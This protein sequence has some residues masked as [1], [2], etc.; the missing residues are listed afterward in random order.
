M[1]RPILIKAQMKPLLSISPENI[2]KLE[3]FWRFK[4]G[5]FIWGLFSMDR[6]IDYPLQGIITQS[7]PES[8]TFVRNKYNM[9]LDLQRR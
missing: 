4:S 5:D 7:F 9:T 8:T 2:R 6:V 3:V 1:I